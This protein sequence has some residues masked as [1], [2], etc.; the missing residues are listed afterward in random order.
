MHPSRLNIRDLITRMMLSEKSAWLWCFDIDGTLV[1]LAPK[2]DL[3][4]VPKSLLEDLTRLLTT[5]GHYA[6]LIS[7]RALEDIHRFFPLPRHLIIAA[8]NHG[9]ETE[10]SGEVIIDP[11]SQAAQRDVA[12][13]FHSLEPIVSS[14]PGTFI[15]NKTYSLSVHYRL[16]EPTHERAFREAV[17]AQA[18]SLPSN[19]SLREAKK[20]L[21]FRPDPGPTKADAVRAILQHVQSKHPQMPVTLLIFGDDRTD[22]DAFAAFRDAVT[23]RVGDGPTAARFHLKHPEEVRRL[24]HL[25]V[26]A[27]TDKKPA[28]TK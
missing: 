28:D 12:R 2:S 22:E 24:I 20:C 17:L 26:Q 23:V 27:L 15:E 6:A 4:Q 8:G 21:E 7:G 9:A 3:I 14:Y 18:R 5:P 13:L 11:L 19:L 25:A 16:M 10:W 1:D